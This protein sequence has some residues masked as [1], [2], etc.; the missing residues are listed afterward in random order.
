MNVGQ[1]RSTLNLTCCS[2]KSC[3]LILLL[4]ST[5]NILRPTKAIQVFLFLSSFLI[6]PSLPFLLHK[7]HL[8]SYPQTDSS[9]N[10]NLNWH[11]IVWTSNN[12]NNHK[13]TNLQPFASI[14][15]K[16]LI[17]NRLKEANFTPIS[18]LAHPR[19]EPNFQM[20]SISLI[21]NYKCRAI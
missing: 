1:L 5:T 19:N 3:S 9:Y 7:H 16:N 17:K 2:Q 12:N 18:A 6:S 15:I 13:S 14:L 8:I 11:S 4:H 20:V 10:N 21:N